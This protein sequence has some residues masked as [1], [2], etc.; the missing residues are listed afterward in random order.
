MLYN[1]N[2][3]QSQNLLS[4]IDL[5]KCSLSTNRTQDPPPCRPCNDSNLSNAVFELNECGLI[6]NLISKNWTLEEPFPSL[7]IVVRIEQVL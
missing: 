6:L 4:K 7:N 3:E 5:L 2:Q 1:S